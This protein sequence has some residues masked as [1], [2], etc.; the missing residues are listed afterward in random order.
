MYTYIR[1]FCHASF[2][3][4]GQVKEAKEKAMNVL[5]PYRQAASH[6]HMVD[7]SSDSQQATGKLPQSFVSLLEFVTEI[8]Q[9]GLLFNYPF[10]LSN[11]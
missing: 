11:S 9:V 1:L 8:Y 10:L 6:D 4:P 7:G 3:A 5:S 2:G